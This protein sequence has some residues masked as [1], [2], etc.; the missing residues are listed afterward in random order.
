MTPGCLETDNGYMSSVMERS[1]LRKLQII[2]FGLFLA[3]GMTLLPVHAPVMAMASSAASGDCTTGHAGKSEC[4]FGDAGHDVSTDCGS[5]CPAMFLAVLPEGLCAVV[6]GSDQ[7]AMA[8][9]RAYTGRSFSPD[10]TP[11]RSNDRI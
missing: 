1:L 2:A 4:D 7:P 6:V 5:N 9:A 8:V 11:P 10:P 3:L